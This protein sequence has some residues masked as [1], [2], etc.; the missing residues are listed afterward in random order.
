M[1]IFDYYPLSAVDGA[2]QRDI[3]RNIWD[4]SRKVGEP[5]Q[6]GIPDGEVMRFLA[7]RGF[8][9]IHN[10][11]SEDYRAMYFHGT[12]ANRATTDLFLFAY[13]EVR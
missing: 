8:S 5:L 13:A 6:F 11:T 1:V 9:G 4:F 3:A 2:D 7:D 12:N 10:V